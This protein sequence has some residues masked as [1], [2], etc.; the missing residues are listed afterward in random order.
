[1][2]IRLIGCRQCLKRIGIN[3]NGVFCVMSVVLFISPIKSDFA[4]Q[5]AAFTNETPAGYT[6]AE[7]VIDGQNCHCRV[8]VSSSSA[9]SGFNVLPFG[10]SS[11][12]ATGTATATAAGTATAAAAAAT[13]TDA[14][15]TTD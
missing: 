12:L 6:V 13:T 11:L 2:G 7:E 1:M 3:M 8:P 9:S 5:L 14:P 10:S 15:T 4:A